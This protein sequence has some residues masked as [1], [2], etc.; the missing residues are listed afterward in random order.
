MYTCSKKYANL[1][2]AHRQHNHAGHC[3]F[4][5]GHN[6]AFEFTFGCTKRDKNGFVI[7]FGDLKWLKEWLEKMFDHT[8]VLNLDDPALEYLRCVL[9]KTEDIAGIPNVSGL[10]TLFPFADLRTVP[11][12]GAEG[13]A[14]W[15]FEEI[16]VLLRA[17]TEDRV[18]LIAVTV[19]EDEKNY[20]TY[21]PEICNHG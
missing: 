3:R 1:P 19:H 9:L 2:F 16:D 5:H 4:I 13:L 12:A 8:L 10:L 20:A 18:F 21:S 15:V 11:N 17:K 14:G 7:D 6:W